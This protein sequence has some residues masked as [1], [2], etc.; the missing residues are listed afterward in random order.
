MQQA[1]Q[2]SVVLDGLK[3][4]KDLIR[5]MKLKVTKNSM[6]ELHE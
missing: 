3:Q 4:E 5:K 2:T 1:P 6:L